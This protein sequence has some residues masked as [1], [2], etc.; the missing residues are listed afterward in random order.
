[1][2]LLLTLGSKLWFANNVPLIEAL[3]DPVAAG[4]SSTAELVMDASKK[5]GIGRQALLKQI[6]ATE[7]LLKTYPSLVNKE[8]VVG[9]YSQ[10]EFLQKI[11]ELD[12]GKADRLALDVIRG[13]ASMQRM[14]DEYEAVKALATKTGSVTNSMAVRDRVLRFERICADLLV[15]NKHKFGGDRAERV[16]Q[17]FSLDGLRL[18]FVILDKEHNPLAAVECR[19]GWS[20]RGQRDAVQIVASL[21]LALRKVSTVWLLVPEDS[22]ILA[23]A[24]LRAARLWGI[25]GL[26]VG[27][28]CDES[29]N[30]RIDEELA[31]REDLT[32]PASSQDELAV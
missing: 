26:H 20:Q 13:N 19:S 27:V 3:K 17:P 2:L 11:H 7:F 8:E 12:P 10:V 18:D 28:V 30:P 32:T 29:G 14:R 6:N 31:P 23:N 21:A 22:R 15:Q 4:Y 9:G 25:A 1:M 16:R 24:V 5:R